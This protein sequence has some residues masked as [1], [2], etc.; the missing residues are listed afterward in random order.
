MVLQIYQV[1][2]LSL[3]LRQ[4]GEKLADDG[5]QFGS[6]HAAGRALT[7]RVAH[8]LG[9]QCKPLP[10]LPAAEPVASCVLGD[11]IEPGGE[12]RIDPVAPERM[13][14]SYQHLLRNIFRI[15]EI[16]RHHHRPA[17]DQRPTCLDHLSERRCVPAPGPRHERR[18]RLVEALERAYD[19][20][21]L[22]SIRE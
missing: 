12:F 4:R 9:L 7:F 22:L 3:P 13:V 19:G 2:D 1:E 5:T 8:G 20:P 18:D 6:E 16:S 17:I 14:Q 10:A 21:G 11:P 15:I